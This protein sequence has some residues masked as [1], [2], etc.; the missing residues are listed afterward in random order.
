MQLDDIPNALVVPREAV[1]IGPDG[2]YVYRASTDGKVVETP[3]KVLFDDGKNA[4]V[5]G[6]LQP[7]TGGDGRPVARGAGRQAC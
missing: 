1:N 2:S 3:V 5:T 6:D 7:A 4:A